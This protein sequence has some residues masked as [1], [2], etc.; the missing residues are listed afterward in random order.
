MKNLL[1][2]VS[3]LNNRTEMPTVLFVVKKILAFWLCY[4]TGL[5]VAEG[6]IILIHF[7]FG[8]NMLV[9]E[10]FDTSIIT[11]ISYYGYIIVLAVAVLYWKLIE[12]KP[13]S[14]MGL[15][16][17]FGNYFV[18]VAIGAI[19]L[20][21][22]VFTIILTGSIKFYGFFKNVDILMIA[23]LVGGFIIQ[24]AAE[25]FLC[26]GVVLHTLKERTSTCLAILVS[27]ILFVIP[28]CASLFD[29]GMVYAI[30]GVINLMLI[31]TIF[32]LLTIHFNSIWVACGLH[33]FWNVIL[34][35]V[36]GLN[37]SGSN[38]NVTAVFS[39]QSVGK[40]MCNGGEYGIEASAI[41]AVVLTI[42]IILIVII[43]K[44]Q[45]KKQQKNLNMRP[46][47]D[48]SSD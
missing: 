42:A 24:G 23:L 20:F 39:M 2:N 15:T 38:E 9:G 45:A 43:G 14:A 28:H 25:E 12:R 44:K 37:L 32:S 21:V 11:L 16:R 4:I 29:G 26:R 48:N 30:V 35:C 33:S 36:L 47:V 18:G 31:S 40:N 27:S 1:K 19:L 13:L 46:E 10:V 22:A 3:P 17:R 7:A 6:I 41:T 34:Y 8:K 5:F